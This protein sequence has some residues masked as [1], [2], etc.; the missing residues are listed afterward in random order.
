V[1]AHEAQRDHAFIMDRRAALGH[2]RASSHKRAATIALLWPRR[3]I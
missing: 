3:G 2:A 1:S